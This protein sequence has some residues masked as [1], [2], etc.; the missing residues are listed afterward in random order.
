[1]TTAKGHTVYHHI[2]IRFD[3]GPGLL[4]LLRQLFLRDDSELNDLTKQLHKSEKTLRK[5]TK[6]NTEAAPK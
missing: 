4:G 1:M 2:T 5:A 3:I 6:Q